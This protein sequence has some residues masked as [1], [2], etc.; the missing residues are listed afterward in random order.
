MNREEFLK[1]SALMGIGLTLMPSLV[2][3]CGKEEEL[4]VT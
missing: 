3:S 2:T 1:M 4:N